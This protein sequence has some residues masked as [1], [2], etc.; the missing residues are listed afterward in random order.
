M[1]VPREKLTLENGLSASPP[2][3]YS[4]HISTPQETGSKRKRNL[5]A[6][7]SLSPWKNLR[8]L[9]HVGKEDSWE[10]QVGRCASGDHL[11]NA[12]SLHVGQGLDSLKK[13]LWRYSQVSLWLY[14]HRQGNYKT[15]ILSDSM[16]NWQSE[17][18]RRS[19]HVIWETIRS[20]REKGHPEDLKEKVVLPR[21]AGWQGKGSGKV[22]WLSGRVNKWAKPRRSDKYVMP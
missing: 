14:Q 12:P 13:M 18:L 22:W 6:S 4:G 8:W 1:G 17:R 15:P 2:T 19:T 7:L 11:S 5:V 9:P 20:L 3:D 16:C 21:L 10:A